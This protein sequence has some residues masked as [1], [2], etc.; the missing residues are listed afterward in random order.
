[1]LELLSLNL[2]LTFIIYVSTWLLLIV[3][4]LNHFIDDIQQ[5]DNLR[6]SIAA[7]YDSASRAGGAGLVINKKTG[8]F[9][10]AI[11]A[12]DAKLKA[13]YA[14]NNKPYLI[15]VKRFIKY[16]TWCGICNSI[17]WFLIIIISLLVSVAM[18]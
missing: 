1:M 9:E 3:F 12:E 6:H 4:N 7:R 11:S 2:T 8:K 16:I 14:R 13:E 17:F 15:Y 10:N 18:L 5:L